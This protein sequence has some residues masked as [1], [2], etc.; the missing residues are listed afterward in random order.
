M[1]ATPQPLE[2]LWQLMSATERLLCLTHFRASQETHLRQRAGNFRCVLPLSN[3]SIIKLVY[4][5]S[6]AMLSRPNHLKNKQ[7]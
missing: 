3:R 5:S 2:M 7:L 1:L 6:T 4:G